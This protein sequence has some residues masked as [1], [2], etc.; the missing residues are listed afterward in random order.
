MSLSLASLSC[1]GTSPAGPDD[2]HT[3]VGAQA[4]G[5]AS[6]LSPVGVSPSGVG[7]S[8]VS[9][10]GTAPAVG[11]T[12]GA[13]GAAPT[14]DASSEPSASTPSVMPSQ[15]PGESGATQ[16]G[17]N[18]VGPPSTTETDGTPAP[19][20]G[21]DGL[22]AAC[23]KQIELDTAATQQTL[24]DVSLEVGGQPLVFGESNALPQGGTIMPTNFRFYL[25]H[26]AYHRGDQRFEAT[27]VDSQ[28]AA[29]P[30][31]VVLVNAEE[32]DSP[33]VQ[34]LSIPGEYDSIS[35]VWGLSHGCNGSL[36]PL[37]PPLDEAAQL[38]W[39]H[40]LG[41]L[42]LRFEAIVDESAGPEVPNE[43]HMGAF[44][45]SGYA[46]LVQLTL[47]TGTESNNLQLSIG[48][49]AILEGASTEADLSDFTLPPPA[50]TPIGEEIL[51]G[52]RLRRAVDSVGVFSLTSSQ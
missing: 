36:N 46:P 44:W 21:P 41:F 17:Q 28:G 12:S 25:S 50:Q 2:D 15:T 18:T 37:D 10:V 16:E 43:I 38:K 33:K 30:Y 9:P 52:E 6:M 31:G 42:F 34:L 14:S 47:P 39:P 32:L 48:L 8:G 11:G 13:A 40:A 29:L 3:G 1:A 22:P 20:T 49:D 4:N 45:P 19:S 7:P 26:F 24:L 5:S 23:S 51:A 27:P 35:F